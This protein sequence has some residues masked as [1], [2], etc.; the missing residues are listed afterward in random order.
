MR[1]DQQT[2]DQI[3]QAAEISEVIGDYVSLKKKGANLWACCPFHGEKSPSFSVS[4]S[5]GIYKCFG[6][7]KS[8]DSVRFIMDIEGLGY[9]EALKHL[10]K[11]YSI[12]IQESKVTD[13]QLFE[14][15]QRESLF[16]ILNFAKNYYQNLLKEHDEGKAIG[17]SYFKERG[18]SDVTIKAF[19]L[20]YSLDNWDAF[21]KK[22]IESGYNLDILD[23][24]GLI[25]LKENNKQFDRFRNRVIF[26][27]HNISGKV[28][29]FGARI[30]KADKNSPKYLNSP[31]TEVYHKSN[32]LYGIYQAK[33]EIRNKDNC[34][35]VEGYTD[36]ISLHQAG[37]HNVV[38]SSGTSLTE[39]QIRLIRRFTKNITVLYDGDPAGIKASL[40]GMDMILREDMDVKLVTF[41]E[42][43]D[44]D[45]YVKKIGFDAFTAHLKESAT[46]FITFKTKLFLDEAAGDPFKKASLI[47]EIVESISYIPDLVKK[48]VFLRQTSEKLGI[49]EEILNNE[50][51]RISQEKVKQ[52]EKEKNRITQKNTQLS[53]DLPDGISLSGQLNENLNTGEDDNFIDFIKIQELDLSEEINENL[54]IPVTNLQNQEQECIR[55]LI[56]YGKKEVDSQLAPNVTLIQYV[57][58]EIEGIEF[59][60]PIFKL[61][62]EIFRDNL[63]LGIEPSHDFFSGHKNEEI[64]KVAT[65]LLFERHCISE[66]W[67][68]NEIIVPTELDKLADMA[69][70]NILRLRKALNEEKINE[71]KIKISEIKN[72][73]LNDL[74]ILEYLEYKEI[75]KKL[76]KEL[77]TVV[78]AKK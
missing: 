39:E 60:T 64:Q 61:F 18:F 52:A 14:Q 53:R 66:G 62:L 75:D 69:F 19:E 41:P 6:C 29:A 50:L 71:I 3:K 70:T 10:A 48:S 74:L 1:I 59:R 37:I 68:K 28:I 44:P 27:I 63:A 20:G 58:S 56:N 54:S 31:E 65:E 43:E 33:N 12:D 57:M 17:Y 35:L 22:A 5:K 72:K 16:I 76:A 55:L 51:K 49:N 30:L 4:P 73:E 78:N 45:S 13:Q 2:I 67:L 11:K 40:R 15:N 24:A 7:S 25:I 36:V 32:S 42:G 23:K 38:A 8:G 77:G 34:F 9:L 47:K 46:D 26:P 21:T